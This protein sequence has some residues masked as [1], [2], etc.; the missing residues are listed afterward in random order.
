MFPQR[1]TQLPCQIAT[2]GRDFAMGRIAKSAMH[3]AT[4]R[5]LTSRRSRL[6]TAVATNGQRKRCAHARGGVAGVGPDRENM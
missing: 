2:T 4:A 3:S 6:Q 1:V 5:T